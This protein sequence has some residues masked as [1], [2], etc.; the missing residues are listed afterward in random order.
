MRTPQDF[1]ERCR[2]DGELGMAIRYWTGGL[3]IE[4]DGEPDATLGWRVRDGA[5]PDGDDATFPA[6]GEPGVLT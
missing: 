4:L 3:R 2:A 1:L 5:L 6:A